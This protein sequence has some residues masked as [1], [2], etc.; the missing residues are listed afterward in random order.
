MKEFIKST[1]VLGANF[2]TSMSKVEAVS[3]ATAEEMQQLR[4]KAKEMGKYPV[5][6]EASIRKLAI[7]I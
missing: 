3:G 5:R 4:D 7:P 6:E 1:I 2:D